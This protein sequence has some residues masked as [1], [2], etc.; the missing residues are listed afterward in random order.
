ML[1]SR[2]DDGT[3]IHDTEI[4]LTPEGDDRTLLVLEQRGMPVGRLSGYGVGNQ[5]NVEALVAYVTGRGPVDNESRFPE[6]M[7]D[8]QRLAADV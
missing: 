7:P 8:Y 2:E 6:L 4:T 5:L 1:R 3:D